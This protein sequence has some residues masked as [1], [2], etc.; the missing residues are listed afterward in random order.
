M[1]V[2]ERWSLVVGGGGGKRGKEGE[3]GEMGAIQ[4]LVFTRLQH[5][6]FLKI[7]KLF[8]KKKKKSLF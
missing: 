5:F 3:G 7:K 8:L 6:S 4:H 1:P 2:L